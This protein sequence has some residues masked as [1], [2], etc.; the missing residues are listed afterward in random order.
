MTNII[1]FGAP[2]AGKGTQAK[3]LAQKYYL[4]HLSSGEILRQETKQG[5]ESE[6]I[7]KYLKSGRL[8]PEKIINEIMAR[9]IKKQ[10][11]NKGLIFDGFPRTLGQA[12]KLNHFL[13]ASGREVAAVI[14][15]KINETEGV[16]RIIKRAK[17]SGRSDDNKKVIKDRFKIYREEM[18][19]LANYYRQQKK[20]ILINGLGT[21]KQVFN[22][23]VSRLPDLN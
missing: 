18:R 20:L 21:E 15:I 3:L 14:E 5:S 13:K 2:G 8:V 9:A 17:T 10:P 19:S 22:A 16:K 4:H 12:K 1:I 6:K 7:Q 23:I 11:L